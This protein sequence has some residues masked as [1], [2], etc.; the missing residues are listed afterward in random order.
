M[1]WA[2]PYLAT[3]R[4]M[5]KLR[6][7]SVVGLL[8]AA[9]AHPERSPAP[10]TVGF[11]GAD[12]DRDA[13]R[14]FLGFC[15]GNRHDEVQLEVAQGSIVRV[16]GS[17]VTTLQTGLEGSIRCPPH[18]SIPNDS[19][20]RLL[21]GWVAANDPLCGLAFGDHEAGVFSIVALGR[22]VVC[23]SFRGKGEEDH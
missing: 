2:R 5:F 15:S 6:I 1:K 19:K 12:Y 7:L 21:V 10:C 8:V 14:E 4:N 13:G 22:E 3:S 18:Q 20:A 16:C 23:I 9:C 11:Y 17:R